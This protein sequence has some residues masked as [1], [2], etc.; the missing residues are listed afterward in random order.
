[1]IARRRTLVAMA[2]TTSGLVLGLGLGG[3]A[4]PRR[5]VPSADA[6][7]RQWSGRLSLR[8][9]DAPQQAVSAG[10]DL[11]GSA[12]GGSLA[13]TTPLGNTA[14]L[15]EW[16][17][18]GARL[19]VPGEPARSAPSLDALV[20]SA[21]GVSVPV[22]ALFDWLEGKPTTAE[23]WQADL[24][25]QARGRL[26]ARRLKPPAELRLVFDAR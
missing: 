25:Q 20:Q 23:G 22:A 26:V 17:A 19:R 3:C 14:A 16:S 15:L 8:V 4:T 5:P 9:E 18:Q 24:S 2:A 21:L 12:R 6:P 7:E 10:F 11:R 13:L 1:M